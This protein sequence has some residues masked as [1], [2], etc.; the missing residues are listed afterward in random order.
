MSTYISD[1]EARKLMASA[2]DLSRLKTVAKFPKQQ[3]YVQ[4]RFHQI[5]RQLQ[6]YS[7]PINY[8]ALPVEQIPMKIRRCFVKAVMLLTR[9]P[10]LG[11][12]LTRGTYKSSVVSSYKCDCIPYVWQKANT[13]SELC[14]LFKLSP[15]Y[16]REIED[17]LA[18]VDRRIKQQQDIIQT[19]INQFNLVKTQKDTLNLFQA[20]FGNIPIPQG[21]INCLT[22]KMQVIFLLDYQSKSLRADVGNVSVKEQQKISQFSTRISQFNFQQFANF[23]SFGYVESETINPELIQNIIATTGYS[24]SEILKAIACST[25]IV[26]TSK[27]E[28]FL[29]HD[30]WG[31]YWQSFLTSFK[32]DHIYLAQVDQDLNSNSDAK[33]AQGIIKLY[34]LFKVREGLVQVDYNLA[35]QFFHSL[36]KRHICSL[37]THLVGEMLA[38]M[39]EYKWLSQNQ[40]RRDLLPSS[41]YMNYPTKLDLTLKDFIFLFSATVKRLTY[42]DQPSIETDLINKFDIKERITI[43]SLQQALNK[44]NDIFINE[45]IREYQLSNNI[46]Q[47]F[48]ELSLNLVRLINILNQLYVKSMSNPLIPWQDLILLFVGNYHSSSNKQNIKQLNLDLAYYFYPCWSI[49]NQHTK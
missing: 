34:E 32:K 42:L 5:H 27:A 21:S 24:K 23:P 8:T 38:D 17:L 1:A 49:L 14:Q 35:K 46:G 12:K 19:L 3:L 2:I 20:V 30:I 26:P 48:S 47:Q 18:R 44:L 22:T 36:A 39:N 16:A 33:T 10:Q 4:Q 31:H 28:S 43:L 25:S 6:V 45:Y 40:Q 15:T 11:G 9:Y 13:V 7:Y 37:S 29:L 41:S